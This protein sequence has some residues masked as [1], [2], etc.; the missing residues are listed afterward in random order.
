VTR[1]L[2]RAAA[3]VFRRT[4]KPAM[5]RSAPPRARVVVE[6]GAWDEEAAELA[7]FLARELL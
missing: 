5:P 1:A 6:R 3:P 4:G 7:A 2:Q